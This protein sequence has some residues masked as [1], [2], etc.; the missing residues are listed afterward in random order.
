MVQNK[1]KILKDFESFHSPLRKTCKKSFYENDDHSLNF[2]IS[3]C[4]NLAEAIND[5]VL[6]EKAA[7]IT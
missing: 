6:K 3:N 2:Y 4:N 1:A 5:R 7:Q